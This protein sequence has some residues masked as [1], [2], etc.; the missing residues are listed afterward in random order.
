MV[1]CTMYIQCLKVDGKAV[2]V[3]KTR[4]GFRKTEYDNGMIKLND[5]V[6]Q[7]HGYAQRTTNEWPAI[8][9]SVPAWMSDFSNG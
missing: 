7:M 5:R 8:G 1:I 2:D 3:V 6:I 4:T 9:M